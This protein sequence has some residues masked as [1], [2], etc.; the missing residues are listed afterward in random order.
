M[1]MTTDLGT[2]LEPSLLLVMGHLHEGMSDRDFMHNEL[3]MAIL[4]EELGYRSVWCVEHHFDR[5]YSMCPDN[6]VLLAHLAAKTKRIKVGIGAAILP[7]NDP[8]RVAE[9]INLLDVLTDGRVEVAFGRGLSRKE[10]GCFGIPMD[11]ARDRWNEAY[12]MIARSFETGYIEGDGPHFKQPRALIT[13]FSGIPLDGRATEIAVSEDSWTSAARL[14][15]RASTFLTF[16]I[17]QHAPMIQLYRDV[18]QETHGRPAPPP[19][20]AD[21]ITV[22]EDEEE[23]ARLHREHIGGYFIQV[24]RHYELA[25]EHFRDTKGYEFYASAA[26]LLKAAGM[27]GAAEG[28]LAAN[29]YGT[30]EQV[31][32]K[33]RH[34]RSVVGD[35]DLNACFSVGGRPYEQVEQMMRLFS[36]EVTPGIVKM[37]CGVAATAV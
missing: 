10:Y 17:E 35:Y 34:N 12:R 4:A 7:W 33:I 19:A 6:F 29:S 9:K 21:L 18:F 26:E 15:L 27:E 28:Y 22:H 2:G 37:R 3:R 16:A 14:G 31:L 30:P 25:G 5:E 24:M 1:T 20:L 23:A 13:P 32:D 8:L 11:E 36:E